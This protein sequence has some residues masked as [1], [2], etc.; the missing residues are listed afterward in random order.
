[1]L[2]TW[3]YGLGR[4]AAWTSDMKGQWAQEWLEWRDF[5][6]F[7]AQL[8]GWVLPAPKVEGLSAEATLEDGQAVIQLE[9]VDSSGHPL[10][11]L[12]AK[13]KIVDPELE[14]VEIT[15]KQVGAGQYQASHTVSTPGNYLV[16][17]GV[18]DGDQSLGQITLG[19]VVPY[20]PEYKIS[21]IDRGLLAELAS[22]TG[23]IELVDIEQI[24]EHNLPSTAAAREIW[25]PLLLLA[26]LLFPIDVG[27]R[28]V[29]IGPKDLHR[30]RAW[31]LEHLPR[32]REGVH[33][34]TR[35]LG[36]L[37]RARDRARHRQ[38]TPRETDAPRQQER[39]SKTSSEDLPGISPAPTEQSPAERDQTEQH[40]PGEIT[41][42]PDGA[43]DTEASLARLREAKKRARRN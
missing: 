26:A 10:N 28:R 32:R 3:Q 2:A 12:D 21:G 37:F 19:L 4:S 42:P 35:L 41:S 36:Q 38:P 43:P 33:E 6:R 9:A 39:I 14:S 16:R 17:L 34:Q 29:M 5:P 7:A 40:P 20:S 11:F 1:L 24:W 27:I 30:V 18:N 31:L 25:Q 23:G 8:V 13:A 15:L 22:I